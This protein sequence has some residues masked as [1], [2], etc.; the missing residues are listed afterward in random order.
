[1]TDA[2]FEIKFI[3]D[4]DPFFQLGNLYVYKL[5]IELFQYASEK[6][7]TGQKDIDIFE[8]LH[9][10]EDKQSNNG[11]LLHM[12]ILRMGSGYT[13]PPIINVG[14]NWAP[15]I[16]LPLGQEVCNGTKRYIVTKAGTTG[17]TAPSHTDGISSNGTLKLR[18]AGKRATAIPIMKDNT[19][20]RVTITAPG[21]GYTSAPD[22]HISP[23]GEGAGAVLEAVIGDMDMP[24]SYGDNNKFKEEALGILFDE[25]N[26]FGE[27]KSAYTNPAFRADT[28]KE[29]TD[30][31]II[32]TD[33]D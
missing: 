9:S 6:I 5:Q 2:L 14:A 1:M 33:E 19:I 8:T 18:Y 4:K 32:T 28:T 17:N 11:R 15:N 20:H 26:P 3:T 22:I 12:N 10:L 16:E 27:I 23:I 13:V 30:E 25:D 29:T 7:T 21:S 24:D 31:P